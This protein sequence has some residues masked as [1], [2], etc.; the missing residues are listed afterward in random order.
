M[1]PVPSHEVALSEVRGSPQYAD[2]RSPY[3]YSEGRSPWLESMNWQVEVP[4]G[5]PHQNED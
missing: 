1:Y 2:T 5:S 3:P 4:S